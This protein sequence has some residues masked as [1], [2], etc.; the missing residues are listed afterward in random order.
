[1]TN[2]WRVV[3]RYGYGFNAARGGHDGAS[4]VGLLCQFNFGPEPAWKHFL[5]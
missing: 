4:S 1:M 3:L 2:T 5:H